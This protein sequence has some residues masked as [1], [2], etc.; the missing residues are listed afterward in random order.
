MVWGVGMGVRKC[1]CG[2]GDVVG[3]FAGVVGRGVFLV[4]VGVLGVVSSGRDWRG[5][6]RWGGVEESELGRGG[7][8]GMW[9]GGGLDCG[10]SKLVAFLC[11]LVFEAVGL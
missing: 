3:N 6:Y 1:G 10:E 5:G 9:D 11:L 2:S 7:V 4:V 8:G